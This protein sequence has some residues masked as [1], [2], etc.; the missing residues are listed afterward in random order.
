VIVDSVIVSVAMVF[1]IPF[2]REPSIW[3]WRGGHTGMHEGAMP[4]PRIARKPSHP[5]LTEKMNVPVCP[6]S[7]MVLIVHPKQRAES[8]CC[9]PRRN[10]LG[11][12]DDYQ[13]PIVSPTAWAPEHAWLQS[14]SAIPP[15]IARERAR[16][17]KR[18]LF[19]NR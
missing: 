8:T 11:T 16:L 17:A 4:T 15:E 2:Y 6:P 7:S 9:L 18:R 10:L 1:R 19:R 13:D 5:C 3:I 14:T 12:P